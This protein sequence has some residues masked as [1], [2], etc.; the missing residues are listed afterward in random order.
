MVGSGV[1]GLSAA[2]LLARGGREVTL[3]EAQ[4]RAGGHCNTVEVATSDGPV[5]VDTGF[6]VYNEKTYPNLTAFFAHMGIETSASDMSF[7]VSRNGLEYSGCGVQGLFA[8]RRNLLRP[9][10]WRML[11]DVK[12]FYAQ[13]PLLDPDAAL[14]LGDLL[15]RGDYSDTFASD[16][17]LPMAAA[18]WS[19]ET[20]DMRDMQAREFLAF[21]ANHGLLQLRDRPQWRTVTGGSRR[22]VQQITMQPGINLQLNCRV[23]RVRRT[24]TGVLVNVMAQPGQQQEQHFDEV[25]FATH[26]DQ[27]L[28]L[29]EDAT[30]HESNLLGAFEYSRATAVLHSDTSYMPRERRAWASWNYLDHR[31]ADQQ[32]HDPL[33]LSY[34]MN[35]LQPLGTDLPIFVTLNPHGCPQDVHASFEYEH[36]VM[37]TA[38]ARAREKLW[39]LQGQR[40]TWF[41][42]AYFGNGF[43]E[44]GLQAGLAVAEEITGRARP[45]RVAD[46]DGRIYRSSLSR[47]SNVVPLRRKDAA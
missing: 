9:Q 7:S 16:H 29:L 39:A 44:D 10:F 1:A 46:A 27:A 37:N 8:Q 21:F 18:I 17:L 28:N 34:W 2:W 25:V 36:P 33:C 4:D 32:T 14:T 6:I 23:R 40:N 35:R 38:S 5:A 20:R 26:A 12:R 11:R 43:H 30:D 13:A 31:G 3:I 41:C 19:T 15:A 42:G 45:W 22:Y 24:A 47:V